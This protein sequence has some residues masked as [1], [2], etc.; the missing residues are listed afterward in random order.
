M[1]L[2]CNIYSIQGVAKKDPSTKTSIFSKQLNSFVRNFQGLLQRKFATDK[3]S[4]VQY[5]ESSCK[6]C[7]FWFSVRYFHVDNTPL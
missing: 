6:W 7:D 2:V 3:T 4:F 5:Y 1:L